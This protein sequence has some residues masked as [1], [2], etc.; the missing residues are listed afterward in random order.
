[1]VAERERRRKERGKKR[2]AED[3]SFVNEEFFSSWQNR[4]NNFKDNFA[5]G[6]EGG[7]QTLESMFD[8]RDLYVD[9]EVPFELAMQEGGSTH[10]IVVKRE[11]L[12]FSCNGTRER[13]GSASLPCYSCKGEG[14]KEDALFHK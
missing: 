11:V 6:Q 2:G 10:D 7:E 13:T 9:I 12:C 5:D 8:G 3:Y 4:T 1:M 14:I